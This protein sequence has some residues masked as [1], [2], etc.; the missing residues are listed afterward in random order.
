MYISENGSFY[1]KRKLP[2]LNEFIDINDVQIFTMICINYR[3]VGVGRKLKA[4]AN[5]K[6]F[7][8]YLL[9]M[10]SYASVNTCKES[11]A[12]GISLI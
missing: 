3:S 5:K 11:D 12:P 1:K 2:K 6:R 9:K 8:M 7:G 4:Y 10:R